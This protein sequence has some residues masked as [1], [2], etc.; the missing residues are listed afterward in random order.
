MPLPSNVTDVCSRLPDLLA[1]I[2]YTAKTQQQPGDPDAWS[3]V[4]YFRPI[5]AQDLA[6]CQQT[7]TAA[8]RAPDL[9]AQTLSWHFGSA[10]E[11]L[12]IDQ[13]QATPS[14]TPGADTPTVTPSA[15]P[16]ASAAPAA[17]ATPTPTGTPSIDVESCARLDRF[18]DKSPDLAYRQA[19][20]ELGIDLN[21]GSATATLYLSYQ[22]VWVDGW[23]AESLLQETAG[24]T[25]EDP[26]T[27]MRR[28]IP[29]WIRSGKLPTSV[30][31]SQVQG[32]RAMI[33]GSCDEITLNINRPANRDL[34]WGIHDGAAPPPSNL[35]SDV[36]AAAESGIADDYYTFSLT[37]PGVSFFQYITDDLVGVTR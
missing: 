15:T 19:V 9:V 18:T 10:S 1:A 31:I 26:L 20:R 2:D 29:Q 5:L 21:S 11:Q 13:G 22:R 28:N 32:L 16:A 7:G 17:T 4:Q 6:W 25:I 23:I 36:I 14:P 27:F 34:A 12:R 37:H 24:W 30:A 8:G 35:T 3:A 33:P